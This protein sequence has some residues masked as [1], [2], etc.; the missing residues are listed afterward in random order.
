MT[1]QIGIVERMRWMYGVALA[2]ILG[3]AAAVAFAGAGHAHVFNQSSPAAASV[4]AGSAAPLD[5]RI[6]S[7]AAR[8]PASMIEA[9]VQFQARVSVARAKADAA[10][11]GGRVFGTL[12]IINGLAM[13]M[14]AA[15][16]QRLASSAD[17]HSVS[18]NSLV[19][20][21]HLGRPERLPL[22]HNLVG[23]LR[24]TYDGTL[25]TPLLWRA[26]DTGAGVG[27]A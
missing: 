3:L 16:A 20:S 7:L 11:A 14:T 2:A 1:H 9:I 22:L 15:Q 26:G 27:V 25:G 17:V 21:Q 8:H 12:Q 18:L 4:P 19:V 6:A 23:Q 10:S 24:T 13:T 5:P